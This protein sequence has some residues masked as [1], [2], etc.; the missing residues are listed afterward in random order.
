MEPVYHRAEPL[1]RDGDVVA[2]RFDSRH[3]MEMCRSRLWLFYWVSTAIRSTPAFTRFD[4][5]KSI[6]R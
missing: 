5:A 2:S 3:V 6:S 4:S 1:L